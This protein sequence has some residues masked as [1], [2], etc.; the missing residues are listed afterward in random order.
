MV[1]ELVFIDPSAS[2]PSISIKFKKLLK[3]YFMKRNKKL[4][5]S[6]CMKGQGKDTKSYSTNQSFYV[7]DI[8]QHNSFGLGYIQDS[9]GNKIEVLFEDKIRV[10]I[11]MVMF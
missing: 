4:S 10:L 3:G 8:I 1:G 6:D 5:W 2:I 11:H 9:F 7:G